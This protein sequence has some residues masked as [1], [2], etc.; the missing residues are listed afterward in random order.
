[1]AFAWNREADTMGYSS[2]SDCLLAVLPFFHI[3]GQMLVMFSGLSCGTKV[4]TLPNFQPGSFLESIQKYHV[5][6]REKGQIARRSRM[7]VNLRCSLMDV[8]LSIVSKLQ[9]NWVTM[10]VFIVA[11]VVVV[12]YSIPIT[13][14][15]KGQN[16]YIITKNYYQSLL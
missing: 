6:A 11:V 12:V 13:I 2:G 9:C 10:L 8:I 4:V 5:R 15:S 3:Y 1:M 16:Y 14:Y 7:G